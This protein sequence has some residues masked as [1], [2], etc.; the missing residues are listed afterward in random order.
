MFNLEKMI[1]NT[2]N[3]FDIPTVFPFT[4]FEDV[5]PQWVCFSDLDRFN[6]IYADYGLH[7]FTSDRDFECIWKSPDRY[8]PL[9]R[10]FGAVVMPDFSIYYDIPLA[11]QIYNKYRSH[12]L[13]QYFSYNGVKVIP[14]ISLNVPQNDYILGSGYP[15]RS[16]VAV[17]S[18]G[19]VR[20][21][22]ETDIFFNSV[23]RISDLLD[24]L[25]ILHFYS[26]KTSLF[27]YDQVTNIPIKGGGYRG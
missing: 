17:S 19:S 4:R 1:V 3:I 23:F 25:E 6:G 20:S 26:A 18:V 11:L 5:P 22:E 27:L 8:I 24:P 13:A 12:W 15:R 2:D 14:N 21:T 16:I 7:F 9:L 10:R